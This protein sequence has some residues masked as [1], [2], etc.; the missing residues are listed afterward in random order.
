[1]TVGAKQAS[2]V[3]SAIDWKAA[4][5][6]MYAKGYSLVPRVLSR[7]ICDAFIANYAKLNYRK[8]VVMERHRFGI[9]E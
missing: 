2:E 4:A 8:T 3:F 6:Q 1:M 9:G 5:D 7:E